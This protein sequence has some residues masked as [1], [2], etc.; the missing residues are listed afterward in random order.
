MSSRRALG[1]LVAGLIAACAA[2]LVGAPS[3]VVDLS[4]LAGALAA[5]ELVYLRPTDRSPLPL[6]FAVMTVIVT[7]A[8]WQAVIAIVVAELVA[9]SVN[10]DLRGFRARVLRLAE[11]CAEA[12]AAGAVYQLATASGVGNDRAA[13]LT[14]LTLA[15][16]APVVVADVVGYVRYRALAPIRARGA[17]VAIV[18]SGIL[19]AVGYQGIDG[20]G[21]LGLWGP[22]L[23]AIPLIA[24]WYSFELLASTRKSFEQT[25]QALAAAPELGGLVRVGHAER[26]ADLSL[27]MGRTLDL[28][29]ADLEQLHTAALL[30]HLGAVCLDEP[31][32]G[33]SLDP[34]AVATAGANMLRASDVLAPA[35]DVVAAEPLLHRPPGA[36]DPPHAALP[37]MILKVASAYDELTEGDDE[38]AAWAVEALYT[39]PGYVYDGRVLA[40]LERALERRGA[41]VGR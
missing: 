4:L 9:C 29:P 39:G 21:R 41:L 19:M 1:L 20:H 36:S 34:V 10:S 8:P 6:S 3:A 28:G 23:F 18:T 11:R 14:A 33:M 37:G 12:F 40:A 32:Q 24:A 17:D 5:G 31:D 13:D 16:L 35:G 26:V 15:A 7:S 25:V 22:V 38:H 2:R 30:H 27:A